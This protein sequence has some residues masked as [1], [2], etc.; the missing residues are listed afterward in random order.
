WT[1][2]A[3]Q[4][5]LA[6][7]TIKSL[8][9]NQ[10]AINI[11]DSSSKLKS[12]ATATFFT[13]IVTTMNGNPAMNISYYHYQTSANVTN[14]FF[15]SLTAASVSFLQGYQTIILNDQIYGQLRDSVKAGLGDEAKSSIVDIQL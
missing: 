7:S 9:E 4:L 6:D 12:K 10:A 11:L 5:Q 2:T 3:S 15:N 14:T 1:C 8:K 13:G